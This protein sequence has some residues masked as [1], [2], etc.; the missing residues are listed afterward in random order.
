MHGPFATRLVRLF[1][2]TF[3]SGS[4]QFAHA[5][6]LHIERGA[7]GSGRIFVTC[8]MDGAEQDCVIDTGSILS[9]AAD[10]EQFGAYPSHGKLRFQSAAGVPVEADKIRLRTLVLDRRRFSNVQFARVRPGNK[11]QN[12]I[13]IDILSK[14]PFTLE[15][16]Q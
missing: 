9:I 10:P 15:F 2:L 1:L 5:A 12:T 14:Q 16:T 3:F 8:T 7:L 13:G 4:L 6:L 11:I